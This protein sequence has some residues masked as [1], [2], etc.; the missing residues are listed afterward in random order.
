MHFVLI[1]TLFGVDSNDLVY[2][3]DTDMTAT[4]CADRMV[5]QQQLLEHTFAASDF[6][7]TCESD[8]YAE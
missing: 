1:L 2:A 5:E 8:V 3:V 7:L 4:D 6:V